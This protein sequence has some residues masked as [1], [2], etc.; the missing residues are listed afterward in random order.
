MKYGRYQ[1][2]IRLNSDAALPPYKGSTFRGLF[3][4]ALKRVV[5]ALKRQACDSCILRHQCTYA[6]A[7]ETATALASPENGR[8]SAPP[9]PMVLEP[10]LTTR[11]QFQKNDCLECRLLL[12]GRI[13]DNLPY[14]VYAFKEM[15]QTGLGRRINGKRAAFDLVSVTHEDTVVYHQDSDRVALPRQLPVLHLAPGTVSDVSRVSLRLITPFR[16]HGKAAGQ[17]ELP[18]HTLVRSLIRRNTALLNTWGEG[19]PDLDYPGLAARALEIETAANDLSWFDW[20]RYSARQDRKMPMGGLTG[21]ITYTGDL[22]PFMPFLAMAEKVHAGKNT[23]FGLGK[24]T[25]ETIG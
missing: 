16:I 14:F 5:C 7:F 9:H 22:T 11:Q 13:N 20:Q 18:F 8:I 24:L 25:V 12:F 3:G 2:T 17:P 15:G 4:I 21:S 23:A 10:P 19:E 1:F 6:L